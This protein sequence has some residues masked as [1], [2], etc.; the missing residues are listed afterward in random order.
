[1]E[2]KNFEGLYGPQF[3]MHNNCLCEEKYKNG[4]LV[5]PKLCNFAPY[6]SKQISLD[7]GV[8]PTNRIRLRGIHE[9]GAELPEI[10]I[11][12]TELNAFNWLPEHWG[13]D[14]ILEMG[15]GVRDKIRYAIQTSASRA[16]RQK[17]YTVTGWRWI[18]GKWEY[19]LPGNTE[20]TV[21]L[22]GKSRGY[23]MDGDATELDLVYLTRLVSSGPVPD[24]MGFPLLALVFLS[25]LNHF[26]KLAGCEPKFV[27]FLIG[28]TGTRKSTL[29]ALL[30]SFFGRFTAADLPL[31]FQDTANSILYH[32]FALKDVMTCIDDFHPATRYEEQK[33]TSTAQTVLRAYGDRVGRGRLRSDCSPMDARPPQGNAIITAEFPPDIGESGTARYLSL[34]LRDGDMDLHRLSHFQGLAAEGVFCRC[35]HRF[36]EWLKEMQLRE[37]NPPEGFLLLLQDLFR[38]YRGE[39]QKSGIVCH[40][41]IAETVAWLRIGMDQLA[42]FLEAQQAITAVDATYLRERCCEILYE[43]ARKQAASIAE[44]RPA[45]RFL[46]KLM[47]MLEAGQVC[48]LS[49]EH[50][51]EYQ[52]SNCIGY[53][54]DSFWYLFS[55]PAHKAV[56]EQ[57]ERQGEAF[58]ISCRELLKALAAEGCLETGRGETTKKIRVDGKAIRVLWI[59]KEKAR[60]IV[61]GQAEK[62]RELPEGDSPAQELS[63][64][65]QE[66]VNPCTV[67]GSAVPAS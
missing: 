28:R 4:K 46:K 52:P 16:E 61:E 37:Q 11:A 30:L 17:V 58:T 36:T 2:P 24:R 40:G 10:E 26:L 65:G 7:D 64:P 13:P 29:A 49:R 63:Q 23:R 51:A 14:C 44:D 59:H 56:R 3:R 34:E 67:S 55:D 54:D 43:L 25:P 33:L 27:L 57:C 45:V 1:M 12:A 50:P 42:S 32:S 62:D 18:D 21:T 9:C 31:S 66:D 20:H 5:L 41:R 22:L 19:L 38:R 48:L 6:I 47:G 15:R 8:E 53:E 35:M 60:E 39:F